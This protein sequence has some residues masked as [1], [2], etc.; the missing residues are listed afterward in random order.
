MKPPVTSRLLNEGLTGI[1]AAHWQ[2]LRLTRSD[3]PKLKN[4][5]EEHFST[6]FQNQA[7]GPSTINYISTYFNLKIKSIHKYVLGESKSCRLGGRVQSLSEKMAYMDPGLCISTILRKSLDTK[8][9]FMSHLI[10]QRSCRLPC[11]K[12]S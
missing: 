11:C 3:K 9:N 2:G 10:A 5:K 6:D 1:L 8:M 12:K 7:G 4:V